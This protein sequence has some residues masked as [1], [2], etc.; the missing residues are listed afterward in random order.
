MIEPLS[1]DVFKK[2]LDVLWDMIYWRNTDGR[3]VVGLDDLKGLF[4]PW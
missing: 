4:Q 3:L 1:L 2:C